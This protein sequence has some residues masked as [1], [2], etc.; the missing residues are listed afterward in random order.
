MNVSLEQLEAFV[1]TA[2]AAHF[3]QQPA[4]WGVRNLL[5]ARM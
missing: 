5:S 4:V 3:P 1:A 2:D